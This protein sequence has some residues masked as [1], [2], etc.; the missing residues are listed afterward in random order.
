MGNRIINECGFC[1]VHDAMRGNSG[2]RTDG[3]T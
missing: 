1:A 3:G 2:G